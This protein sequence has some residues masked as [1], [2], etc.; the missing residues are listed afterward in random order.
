MVLAESA[1]SIA[2]GQYVNR[3]W[4][5]LLTLLEMNVEYVRCEGAELF[6]EDGRR[7]LDFLSG[8]CVHN[9][10]HNH[11]AIVAALVDELEKCGPMMLQSSAP[12]L[13]GRLAERLCSLA[14]GRGPSAGQ[15][16][17]NVGGGS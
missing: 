13:A 1:N 4:V 9:T 3:Q 5:N 10:G 17:V 7:I 11:P 12:E 2:Y 16:G 15:R 14:G 8:Y 6:T